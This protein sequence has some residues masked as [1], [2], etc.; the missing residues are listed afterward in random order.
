MD[1]NESMLKILHISH[2]FP[3]YEGDLNGIAVQAL[4]KPL[5][6]MGVQMQMICPVRYVPRL[7]ARFS[8]ELRGFCRAPRSSVVIEGIKTHYV[9]YLHCGSRRFL[10]VKGMAA[11]IDRYA[12]ARLDISSFDVIHTHK[13]LPDGWAGAALAARYKKPLVL[14]VRETDL[15][16]EW[17]RKRLGSLLKSAHALA[18]PSEVIRDFVEK[19]FGLSVKPIYNGVNIGEIE[20]AAPLARDASQQKSFL[21]L[22]VSTLIPR[23]GIQ[24]NLMA[25]KALAPRY[26]ELKYFIIGDG[27]YRNTLEAMVQDFRLTDRVSFLGR[28]PRPRVYAYMKMCDLF[29]LPSWNETFGLVYL[30]AMACGLPVIGTKGHGVEGVLQNEKDCLFVEEQSPQS[31][32]E[33]VSRMIDNPRTRQD[34]AKQGQERVNSSLTW[35]VSARKLF[36]LYQAVA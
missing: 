20:A 3:Y 4:I 7:V 32:V 18:T 1:R 5:L 6:R 12:R 31:I 9:R 27:P 16:P 15:K 23:K 29:C 35:D 34:L 19:Q 28:L 22:S 24:C 26:P 8:P 13:S 36:D 10:T 33:A 2:L 11:A 14:T 25:M 17:Y 21:V 30:E